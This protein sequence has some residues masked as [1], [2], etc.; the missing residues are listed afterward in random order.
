MR[1]AGYGICDMGFAMP[2]QISLRKK[3]HVNCRGMACHAH[4]YEN[5]YQSP[6][7]GERN[8]GTM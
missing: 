8:C 3:L 7:V 1:D 6:E 5:G 2:N 4:D